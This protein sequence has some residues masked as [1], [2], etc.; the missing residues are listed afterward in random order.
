MNSR[1]I[2]LSKSKF[3]TTNNGYFQGWGTSLCWWANRLG[4]S[5]ALTER[6]AELFFGDSGLRMNIMRYNIGGGDDPNHRHITRTD[7]MV[8]GWLEYN[9][10]D[11]SYS[12]KYNADIN[13]LNVLKACYRKSGDNAYVEVFSNSPPYFMCKS[14][15]SSGGEDP[16]ENNLKNECYTE[17][18]EYLA[19]VAE[20]INN[21][22]EI[23]VSS[24]S[25]M[26]EPNTDYWKYLSPKQEGCH[27]DC[28]DSQNRIILE[29]AKAIKNKGLK[30]IEIIG[31]DETS[32]DK[33]ILA[34]EGYTDK[35]KKTIDRVSTHTYGTERIA[36]LGDLM[37]KECKNLWMS[38][39]DWGDVAGEDAGEM[40]A[41]LWLAK[42]V[43]SDI[44]NLSP[45]AW[46]LWQTIDYHKSEAGYMGNKD[47]GIPD[48]SK[49]Y[50]GLA[51][52]DHDTEEIILTKKY[53]CL[54]QFTRYINPGDTIIHSEDDILS[55]IN[56]KTAEIKNV[57]INESKNTDSK[58]ELLKLSLSPIQ[59]QRL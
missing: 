40:G 9:K 24:I 13:Q 58:T 47:F 39:T 7:S 16:N 42:K 30:H 45:S 12:Y 34:Y 48:T 21:T 43:V 37:K 23:T 31:S 49:G 29:T 17:F 3:S 56:H 57:L 18:A 41:G 10:S 19:H 14:G 1:I 53:F 51:F 2:T 11:N 52:A 44:N 15:C 27:F 28:G 54:A 5:P 26:N 20:Y 59:L 32:T 22:L 8:P 38:E 35:V 50:W 55:A 33:A 4:Y 25:P 6:S 36:E 46:V